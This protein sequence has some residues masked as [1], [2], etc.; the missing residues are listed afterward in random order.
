[1]S[2]AEDQDNPLA[3]IDLTDVYAAGSQVGVDR[4]VMILIDEEI[5]ALAKEMTL[6]EFRSAGNQR[7]IVTVPAA[8]AARA[9]AIIQQAIVDKILPGEGTYLNVD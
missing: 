4:I 6:S 7:Y 5:E 8:D 1:M 9:R 3:D 2:D